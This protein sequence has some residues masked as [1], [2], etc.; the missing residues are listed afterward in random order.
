[1]KIREIINE[2][3]LT[4]NYIL[5]IFKKLFPNRNPT[6]DPKNLTPEQREL[7]Q[8]YTG[9]GFM[10][11]NQQLRK[12]SGIDSEFSGQDANYDPYDIESKAGLISSAFTK[13]NTNKK[14]ITVY[15]GIST[16]HAKR[17]I[18]NKDSAQRMPS[19]L[20]SSLSYQ[21]A[22]NYSE[23]NA[24]NDKFLSV[25]ECVCP[26]GT[27]LDIRKISK[28]PQEEEVLINHGQK[29]K[30]I[31]TSVDTEYYPNVKI[32]KIKIQLLN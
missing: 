17:I 21:T 5:K 9:A 20:S 18:D 2:Q 4:E 3:Y 30:V 19:F 16:G 27:V 29:F 15:S 14:T 24:R 11:V 10:H 26:P 28:Q 25:L 32:N 1:M 12:K 13:E 23:L 6:G 8:Y 22:L 31:G 7:I